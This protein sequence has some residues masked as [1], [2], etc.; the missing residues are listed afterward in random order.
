MDNGSIINCQ[1]HKL[2]HL[3]VIQQ[4]GKLQLTQGF[5]D[6]NCHGVAEVQT[7]CLGFHGNADAG[8]SVGFQ[9]VFGQTPG[10]FAEEEVSAVFKSGFGIAAGGFCGKTPHL[11]HI[12]A[13]EE[14]IQI[15]IVD[16]FYHM[17][18]VKARTL[19]G[20]LGNV[21]SQGAHKV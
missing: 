5:K 17:P 20:F 16:D 21:K 1:L 10:F 2:T 18:V 15:F 13:G 9:K 4:V 7:S 14:I 8:F 19:D 11:L 6:R 3:T 12:V